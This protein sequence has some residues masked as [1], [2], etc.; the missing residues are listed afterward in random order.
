MI[1]T[2][3]IATVSVLVLLLVL[4]ALSAFWLSSEQSRIEEE[5]RKEEENDR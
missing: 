2:A 1:K 4:F 3:I 5:L